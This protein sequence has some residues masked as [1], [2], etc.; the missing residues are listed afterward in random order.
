MSAHCLETSNGLLTDQI[1]LLNPTTVSFAGA[2]NVLLVMAE[3]RRPEGTS[4][5]PSAPFG[6]GIAH[7]AVSLPLRFQQDPRCLP[8]LCYCDLLD[9]RVC[10]LPLCRNLRRIAR[11]RICRCP[12]EQGPS[13]VCPS[14]SSKVTDSSAFCCFAGL[15]RCSSA[16]ARSR[17]RPQQPQ[18]RKSASLA[19]GP[20][21]ELTLLFPDLSGK[22]QF[23]DTLFFVSK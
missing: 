7:L 16:W 1:R 5:V 22:V 10:R 11:P 12:F 2:P 3:M 23:V 9:H 17:S 15:L 20:D 21:F 4:V 18:S 19:S 8:V 6:D 14:M 13:Q